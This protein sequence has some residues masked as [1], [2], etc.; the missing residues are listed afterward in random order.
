[1]HLVISLQNI[2]YRYTPLLWITLHTCIQNKQDQRVRLYDVER[3]WEL[4]KDVRARG[5]RCVPYLEVW[6]GFA[7]FFIT[8]KEKDCAK[9]LMHAL[10]D[11]KALS[12][13]SEQG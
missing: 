3:D 5:I 4:R 13:L 6:I 8:W 9:C 12:V 10:K 7:C 1:V 2:P 11:S